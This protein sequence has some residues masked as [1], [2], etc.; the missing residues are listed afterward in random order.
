MFDRIKYFKVLIKDYF[1]ILIFFSYIKLIL[2][3]GINEVWKLKN[4]M[5]LD[6]VKLEVIKINKFFVLF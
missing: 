4:Y 2:I 5:I 1:E 6:F 3:L